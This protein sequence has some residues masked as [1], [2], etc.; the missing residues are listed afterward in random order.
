M[1]EI[2]L[3]DIQT[4]CE[5]S[6]NF[7]RSKINGIEFMDNSPIR[8]RQLRNLICLLTVSIPLLGGCGSDAPE[9]E[10]EPAMVP[11]TGPDNGT[12]VIAGGNIQDPAIIGRFMELAGGLDAPIV[13]VPT[14]AEGEIDNL[15]WNVLEQLQKVGAT[16]LTVLHTRNPEEADT[17]VFVAPLKSTAG[18]WFTGGRQWRIADS[19]LGTL[20]EKEFRAVLNRG[21]VIGGSSAGATIQGSYL[22][23][24]D[25]ETNTIMMGDHE[26]GF[27]YIDNVAIDQHLLVR[28]R[29]FDLQE[30]IDARPGLLGLGL[31][32]DTAIVVTGDNFDVIGQGYVAIYDNARTT[33][34]DGRFYF[35]MPGDQ[36]NMRNRQPL[37]PDDDSEPFA[38]IRK[39]E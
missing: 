11:T 10:N 25:S 30:I 31:D 27:S 16:N 1:S 15:S 17:E 6:V 20:A 28:N 5:G 33:G 29:Q 13:V 9:S 34:R 35:L 32:E 24:G 39:S 8:L 7:A 21:G 12:L 37:R 19:Y 4:R 23:R 26:Q 22:A 38:I 2:S 36:F 3:S 14:A 18:I